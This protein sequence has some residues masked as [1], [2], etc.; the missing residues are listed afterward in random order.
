MYPIICLYVFTYVCLLSSL[1]FLVFS[2]QI[3]SFQGKVPIFHGQ[4]PIFHGQI[5]M[6]LHEISNTPEICCEMLACCFRSYVCAW[7]IWSRRTNDL[8]C[9]KMRRE[10]PV[11]WK[12]FC[13]KIVCPSF[14]GVYHCFPAS[15]PFYGHEPKLRQI[16]IV[17]MFGVP[18]I[19]YHA[20]AVCN[21]RGP[22]Q[23]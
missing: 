23:Q 7:R 1:Y 11:I 16:Q 8:R 3:P 5:P 15:L 13:L 19:M 10:A 9:A 4:T 12:W 14:D 18:R 21:E 6:F 20:T 2:G 17:E 22:D